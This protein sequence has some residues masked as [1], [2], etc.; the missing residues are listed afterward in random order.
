MGVDVEREDEEGLE[1]GAVN[2]EVVGDEDVVMNDADDVEDEEDVVEEGGAENQAAEIRDNA[3][4]DEEVEDNEVEG[5]VDE[6]AV[7][8][9]DVVL[10]TTKKTRKTRTTRKNMWR[11]VGWKKGTLITMSLK[12]RKTGKKMWRKAGRV[13]KLPK[14]GATFLKTT[15]GRQ[16]RMMML[17]ERKKKS[18]LEGRR[19]LML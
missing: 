8:E 10:L 6:D 5:A 7:G 12:T 19:I 13:M 16:W 2:V 1:E 11:K 14:I 17:W 3:S 18:W 15:R 4:D 9:E